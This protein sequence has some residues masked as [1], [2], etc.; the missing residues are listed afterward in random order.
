M[1]GIFLNSTQAN[2]IVRA[3][4]TAVTGARNKN[5][6]PQPIFYQNNSAF[7]LFQ[8]VSFQADLSC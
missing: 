3:I 6:C 2:L 7:K 5:V 4:T 1:N 8:L